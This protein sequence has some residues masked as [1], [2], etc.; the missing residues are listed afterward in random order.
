[1]CSVENHKRLH[2]SLSIY[3]MFKNIFLQ[4]I[5][6]SSLRLLIFFYTCCSSKCGADSVLVFDLYDHPILI[7][8]YVKSFLIFFKQFFTLVIRQ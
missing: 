4:E 1:M 6:S 5:K 8:Y 7:M 2:C 3:S